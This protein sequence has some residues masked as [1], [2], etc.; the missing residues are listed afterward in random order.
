MTKRKVATTSQVIKI[1][2]MLKEVLDESSDGSVSYKDH[3]TDQY[4]ADTVGVSVNSVTRVRREMF[5]GLRAKKTNLEERI[6]R[7]EKKVQDLESFVE[8]NFQ[9]EYEALKS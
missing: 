8:Q 7:L 1:H 4:I 6:E 3:F 9:L 5:G 2:S